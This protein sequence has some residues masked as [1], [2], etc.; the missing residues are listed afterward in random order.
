DP[1]YVVDED[2]SYGNGEGQC[3]K[4]SFSFLNPTWSPSKQHCMRQMP[5]AA[6]TMISAPGRR[7][8]KVSFCLCPAAILSLAIQVRWRQLLSIAWR[9]CVLM[10]V[11]LMRSK[12]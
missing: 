6:A 1:V 2:G 12:H 11:S 3:I 9:W 7:W 8:A 10:S 5:D 4:C